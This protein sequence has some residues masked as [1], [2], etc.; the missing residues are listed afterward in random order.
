MI[1]GAFLPHWDILILGLYAERCNFGEF[2]EVLCDDVLI[3]GLGTIS[4][5]IATD[6]CTVHGNAATHC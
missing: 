2:C 3:A 6:T 5:I 1:G 4:P